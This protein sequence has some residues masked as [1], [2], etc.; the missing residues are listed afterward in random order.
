MKK[1][2]LFILQYLCCRWVHKKGEFKQIAFKEKMIDHLEIES[3]SVLIDQDETVDKN[4][5]D[6][7]QEDVEDDEGN[8]KRANHFAFL[9]RATQ[10]KIF[11]LQETEAQTDP[12][13]M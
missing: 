13:P 11:D 1:L 6:L 12:P 5:E 4:G 7:E 9:D 10:T 3:T 8:V 2:S